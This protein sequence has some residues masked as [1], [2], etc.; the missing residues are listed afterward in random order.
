MPGTLQAD[1]AV[2]TCRRSPCT[3]DVQRMMSEQKYFRQQQLAGQR[4]IVQADAAA[5]VCHD[6]KIAAPPEPPPVVADLAKLVITFDY[7]SCMGQ[8]DLVVC[9]FEQDLNH[10]SS[11]AAD[12]LLWPSPATLL[13]AQQHLG[14]GGACAPLACH[15]PAGGSSSSSSSSKA[16]AAA[17]QQK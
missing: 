4:G 2:A 15:A 11:P 16:A 9:I 7:P 8:V 14:P 13:A 10:G 1:V 12:D 6:T 5:P 17:R 3:R